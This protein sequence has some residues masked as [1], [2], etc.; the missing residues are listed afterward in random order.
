MVKVVTYASSGTP[1]R[2]ISTS[3]VTRVPSANEP[4]SRHLFERSPFLV[5][6]TAGLISPVARAACSSA[7]GILAFMEA[8]ETLLSQS[9]ID[10]LG[11]AGT[12]VKRP[13]CH[14]SF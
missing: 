5:C 9:R 6:T 3:K 1:N 7:F 12:T 14:A 13:H 10:I 2:D 11:E 4:S 8:A